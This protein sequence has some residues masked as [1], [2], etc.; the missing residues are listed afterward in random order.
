MEGGS[1]IARGR[2][3]LPQATHPPHPP[4]T[5]SSLFFEKRGGGVYNF[6]FPYFAVG[7]SF[8]CWG[9]TTKGPAQVAKVI[10]CATGG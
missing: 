6:L 7:N 5:P 1:G 8:A 9:V 3:S 4:P 10:D 2:G